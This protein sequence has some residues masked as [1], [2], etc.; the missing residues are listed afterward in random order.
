ML[1]W[2]LYIHQKFLQT[3]QAPENPKPKSPSQIFLSHTQQPTPINR[4]CTNPDP[5]TVN[6]SQ[7]PEIETQ[8]IQIFI[9]KKIKD[10]FDTKNSHK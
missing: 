8:N 9:I 1:I 4:P 5:P 3:P 6:P 10:L 2:F 7:P